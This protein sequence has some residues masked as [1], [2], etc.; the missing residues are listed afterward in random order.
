[1]PAEHTPR[2]EA[3]DDA[4]ARVLLLAA[5]LAYLRHE[6]AHAM[7]TRVLAPSEDARRRAERDEHELRDMA[8]RAEAAFFEARARAREETAAPPAGSRD[9]CPI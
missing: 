5:R 6:L 9:P 4:P 1:M 7:T 8:T 2:A 3:D